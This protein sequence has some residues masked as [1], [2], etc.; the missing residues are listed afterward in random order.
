[1]SLSRHNNVPPFASNDKNGVGDKIETRR[2][3]G[4]VLCRIVV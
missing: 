4:R 3:K 1:M 2:W